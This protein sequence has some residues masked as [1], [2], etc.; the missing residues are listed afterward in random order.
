V[1]QQ[2]TVDAAT[3][4]LIADCMAG[5]GLTWQVRDFDR[6]PLDRMARMYGVGDLDRARTH[7]YHFLPDEPAPSVLAEREAAANG[8][9][10][11]ADPNYLLVLSGS[12][13]GVTPLDDPGSYG[14]KK[15]PL[16]GCAAEALRRLGIDNLDPTQLPAE[17]GVTAFV[18][19]GKDPRVVEAV[20]AWSAC[21][22]GK[23]Y[24]YASPSDAAGGWDLVAPATAVEIQTAVDDV[25]CKQST[26]LIGIWYT[27]QVAYESQLIA[28]NI[29][30]LDEVK[31]Q[32]ADATERASEVL[33]S[34]R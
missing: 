30:A 25:R 27:V 26:N 19:S 5:F 28:E 22:K 20:A 15:I 18:T 32:W 7:G 14:G 34:S 11:P 12:P 23:G 6:P 33:A 16:G 17:I 9:Q 8:P 1:E 24:T 2:N 31:Q 21:M 3:D 29:A 10:L 13:D 4:H